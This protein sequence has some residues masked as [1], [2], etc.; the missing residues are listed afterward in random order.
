MSARETDERYVDLPR[1]GDELA[2]V[3]R[4]GGYV[5]VRHTFPD[6]F[7]ELEWARWFPEGRAIDEGR[8]PSFDHLV[9]TWGDAGLRFVERRNADQVVARDLH[10]LADREPPAPVVAPVDSPCFRTCRGG[11]R[12]CR[13]AGGPR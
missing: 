12:R 3:V 9:A 5:L 8:M 6:R 4:P 11:A 7:D 2:R 13:R 10:E 1:V